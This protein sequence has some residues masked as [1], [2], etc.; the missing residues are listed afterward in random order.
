M[1][2]YIESG[3]DVGG[4]VSS[5]A[6]RDTCSD[7][8]SDIGSEPEVDCGGDLA[9]DEGVDLGVEDNYEEPIAG[10]SSSE[11]LG[12]LNDD[13]E[14]VPS[15]DDIPGE[16]VLVDD[17]T[18]EDLNDTDEESEQPEEVS[19]PSDEESEQ[20]EESLNELTGEFGQP[21]EQS[22]EQSNDFENVPDTGQDEPKWDNLTEPTDDD[23]STYRISDYQGEGNQ[24]NLL[25][26][27]LPENSTIL[28][29]SETSPDNFSIKTDDLG[30]VNEFHSPKVD[31]FDGYRSNYQQGRTVDLKDGMYSEEG[32]KLDDAGHLY[33][34]QWGGPP[35]QVNLLP[36]D[37]HINRHGEWRNMEQGINRELEAGNSVT[38]YTVRPDYEDSSRRP[39]GFD[40][41]YNVNGKPHSVYITNNGKGVSR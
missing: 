2:E 7:I 4:D 8:G 24:R 17:D 1:D 18:G 28:V 37:S 14:E 35:E 21:Q 15:E 6:P 40:V 10:D 33:P 31:F 22:T 3:G 5:D 38:D 20:S 13:S 16:D 26:G 11:N 36:M 32:K 39:T 25:N 30:R 19:D 27:E 9:S 41:S 12:D 29:P 34:R 23:K